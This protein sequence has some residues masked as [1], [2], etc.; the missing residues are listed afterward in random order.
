MWALNVTGS[1][2]GLSSCRF[3]VAYVQVTNGHIRGHNA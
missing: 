2:L 3:V 1:V